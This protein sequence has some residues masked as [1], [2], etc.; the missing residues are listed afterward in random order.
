[1]L[2]TASPGARAGGVWAE[3]VGISAQAEAFEY[4][5]EYVLPIRRIYFSQRGLHIKQTSRLN[6]LVC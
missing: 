1:M 4:P 2:K 6:V 3:R 5:W